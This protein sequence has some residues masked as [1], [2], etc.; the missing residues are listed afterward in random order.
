ME[1]RRMEARVRSWKV[2]WRSGRKNKSIGREA[3]S[4]RF[5]YDISVQE[6]PRISLEKKETCETAF[7]IQ[8]S[9]S[10]RGKSVFLDLVEFIGD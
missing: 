6:V 10:Q 8:R 7:T 1:L 3:Y 4:G 9:M 5:K 2:Q